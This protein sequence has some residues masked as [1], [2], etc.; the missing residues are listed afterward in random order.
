MGAYRNVLVAIDLAADNKIIMDRAKS[1][2]AADGMLAILHVM[3]PA[4]FY[5]G[6]APTHQIGMPTA[7]IGYPDGTDEEFIERAT[8]QLTKFGEAYGVPVEQRLLERGHAATHILE[9][10]EKRETDLIVL[11]SHGR[12][13][14]QLLLGSTANAVL[15]RAPCDVLAVRVYDA[16]SD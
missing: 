12:H 5:F 6:L 2:L 8:N 1:V 11:G 3:E 16:D 15:H 10:A 4:Y 7:A 9:R 14:L 13:G